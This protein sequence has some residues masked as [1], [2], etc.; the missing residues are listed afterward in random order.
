MPK[1]LK[2]IDNF[3]DDDWKLFK[4]SPSY[5]HQTD[6][7]SKI[8]NKLKEDDSSL[9]NR[10]LFTKS[11]KLVRQK[12]KEIFCGKL[13]K[14]KKSFEEIPIDFR[15][16]QICNFHDENKLKIISIFENDE[17]KVKVIKKIKQDYRKKLIE[18]FDELSPEDKE[19]Y[20]PENFNKDKKDKK[21]IN[22][23]VKKSKKEII[24]ERVKINDSEDED[25]MSDNDE[26]YDIPQ[27]S[28]VE[29]Q[30]SDEE[31]DDEEDNK[32][33]DDK[34][35]DV[36]NDDNSSECEISDTDEEDNL[37]DDYSRDELEE[38]S[39][40]EIKKICK[41]NGFKKYSKMKKNELINLILK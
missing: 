41:D 14:N 5:I 32:N 1:K 8:Y 12:W 31:A 30:D 21:V 39:V 17:G 16:Y 4:Q 38:M 36:E 28:E 20:L 29:N 15:Y 25:E 11:T 3:S 6:S 40:K 33:E 10:E 22:K 26:S 7:Y 34:K 13:S 18:K 24:K 2:T 27:N 37:D 23:K 35:S 9:T 19:F